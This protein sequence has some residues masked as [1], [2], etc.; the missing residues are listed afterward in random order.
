MPATNRNIKTP[1]NFFGYAPQDV[2]RYLP[3]AG[4]P[5]DPAYS[6]AAQD[7]FMVEQDRKRQQDDFWREQEATNQLRETLDKSKGQPASAL[8]QM[9]TPEMARSADYPLLQERLRVQGQIEQREEPYSNKVLG[10][11]FMQKLKSPAAR[12]AMQEA[13]TSG[14]GAYEAFLQ[15]QNLQDNEDIEIEAASSGI[16]PT[17]FERF[18]N[19]DGTY[20]RAALNYERAQRQ[21]RAK[22]ATPEDVEI[23]FLEK[24]AEALRK[25]YPEALG[26]EEIPGM[27][28]ILTR[29]GALVDQRLTGIGGAPLIG[30]PSTAD[31]S[32]QA[33]A[34]IGMA[35]PMLGGL[36][37]T[38]EEVIAGAEE[39][40]PTRKSL[41]GLKSPELRA[42]T[43]AKAAEES[44]SQRAIN[45]AWT[46]AKDDVAIKVAEV[47]PDFED[48]LGA[49]ASIVRGDLSPVKE[50]ANIEWEAPPSSYA[51]YLL[52]K[53][54]INPLDIAFEE[55]GNQRTGSQ[56]VTFK[57]L[58]EGLAKDALEAAGYDTAQ[59]IA[60]AAATTTAPPPPRKITIGKA[61]KVQ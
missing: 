29:H 11:Q 16:A 42:A 12:A 39:V 56:S 28:N 22:R 27:K 10:P 20:N 34:V 61:E 24:R 1:Q 59:E 15:A 43:E 54:G 6:P 18:K 3:P 14:V 5:Q 2:Y 49:L 48:R 57:E 9:I 41:A 46:R 25:A 21:E 17:E 60:E 35:N 40:K 51:E 13:M 58:I 52:R 4:N 31:V 36:A 26:A 50:F 8:M 55:P 53:A 44:K 38:G 45:Q 30:A 33:R 7:M 23:E 32:P 19:P 37:P 47:F